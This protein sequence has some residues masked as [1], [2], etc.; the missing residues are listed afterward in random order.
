VYGVA[1]IGSMQRLVLVRIR[2]H[3]LDLL[4]RARQRRLR[5]AGLVADEAC[6]ASR[7]AFRI[8]AMLSLET[9]AFGPSSQTIGSLS[10]RGLGVPP[11]VRDH[12]DRGVADLQH[13]LHAPSCCSPRR[14]RRLFTLPP[15][16][17]DSLIAA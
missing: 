5:I 4:R 14:R 6:S 8:S 9:L 16:T 11:V 7:P 1:F 10:R 15:N 12:G 3:G 17:G 13:L 2:V